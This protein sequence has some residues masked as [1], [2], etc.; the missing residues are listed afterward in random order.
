MPSTNEAQQLQEMG[1]QGVFGD[2]QVGGPFGFDVAISRRAA[3]I[4]GVV[5]DVAGDPDIVLLP[6]IIAANVLYKCLVWL[7]QASGASIVVGAKVPIVLPSRSDSEE[8]KFYSVALAVH[9]ASQG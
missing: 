5:S 8:S 4:K 3:G 2:A 1:R 6:E 7:A 9:V